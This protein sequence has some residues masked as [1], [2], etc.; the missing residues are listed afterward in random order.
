MNRSSC[1][2]NI[3]SD[4]GNR[5]EHA[6][7]YVPTPLPKPDHAEELDASIYLIGCCRAVK[8]GIGRDLVKRISMLQ[9][10]CPFELSLLASFHSQMPKYDERRLHHQLERYWLRGEWFTVPYNI[11]RNLYTDVVKNQYGTITTQGER[12]L[13]SLY[14]P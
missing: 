1:G 11:L 3:T 14:M 8:V 6:L 4:L 10:G 12:F 2:L 9:I 13:N 5:L 7:A